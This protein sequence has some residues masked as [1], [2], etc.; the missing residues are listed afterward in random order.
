MG[1]LEYFSGE[2]SFNAHRVG[3]YGDPIHNAKG[4]VI[5]W[6]KP[7][8]HCRSV[9]EMESRGMTKNQRGH[10][11]MGEKMGAKLLSHFEKQKEAAD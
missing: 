7:E 5:G 9:A 8:R 10:W 1:C 3:S 4:K 11:T 2:E 6:T